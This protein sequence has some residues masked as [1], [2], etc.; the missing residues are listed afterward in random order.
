MLRWCADGGGEVGVNPRQDHAKGRNTA[1]PNA[2]SREEGE[3]A[4]YSCQL[5]G[6]GNKRSLVSRWCLS[7]LPGRLL[8]SDF[9]I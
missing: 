7:H 2:S 9:M 4:C 6:A 5:D 1:A 3:Q 8:P